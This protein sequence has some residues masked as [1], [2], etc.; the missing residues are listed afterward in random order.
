MLSLEEIRPYYPVS[1]QGY[2]RFMI[3]E[4]LQ[5][6]ILEIIFD[7]S[8]E[9]K[10][11]FLGGTCLRIVHGNNRF[12]EDLDFDN[13]NL[14]MEDFNAITEIVKNELERLGYEVEMRNVQKGAYHCYIRFP[15]L[16]YKE[17]LSNHKEEKILIQLDTEPHDFDYQPEQPLLNKFDVFTQINATP[18]DLLLAQKFYAVINRK[19]NKGRDFFDIVFLLG[20]GETPNYQYLYTKIGVQTPDELRKRI[21]EKCTQLDMKKMAADVSPFLFDQ[22]DEKKVVLFSK[23]ME[24]VKLA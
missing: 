18:K 7:S 23:Y 14:S 3:R 19:R 5:Y 11:A 16:L 1:L 20:Q 24:Q 2:E 17:G 10:L 15:E 9:N 22:K 21:L 4:Y 12:S 8:F 13:F 6:K